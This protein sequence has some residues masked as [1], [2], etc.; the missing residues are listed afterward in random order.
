MTGCSKSNVTKAPGH[1]REVAFNT[2]FGKAPITRAESATLEYMQT[3]FAETSPAFH[4]NGFLH[5]ELTSDAE[6]N[7]D[8]SKV[9]TVAA[10]MSKDVWWVPAAEQAGIPEET[11]TLKVIFSSTATELEGA[12]DGET[13]PQGWS[14]MYTQDAISYATST[15]A[16]TDQVGAWGPW[17]VVSLTDENRT[18][19][20]GVWDYEGVTYW[21]DATSGRKLAFSAYSLNA[22]VVTEEGKAGIRFTK[23]AQGEESLT[24]FI[25]T[26]PEKVADQQDL[27]V[28]PLLPNQC[29]SASGSQTTVGLVFNHLLTRIGFS[30][31]AN[32]IDTDINIDIKSVT[33]NGVFPKSGVVELKD[34]APKIVAIEG[35]NQASYALFDNEG[36][37]CRYTSNTAAQPIFANVKSAD[38]SV[39]A[40]S[41][42]EDNRYMMIMPSTQGTDAYIEVVYQLTDAEEQTAKISLENWVFR[43]ST[44]YDFVLKVSTSAIGFYV[45]VSPWDHYFA[46][47]GT[48]GNGDGIFTLTPEIPVE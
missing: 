22:P 1:G 46:S 2:Y 39:V 27:L 8:L 26:V 6:G 13:I 31:M 47:T 20:G 15:Y 11:E 10:Y 18:N 37:F 25:Y 5:K 48:N 24:N 17:Q 33:L 44:S 12:Y 23:N 34:L 30:L 4:V 45:E 19:A 42:S 40:T 7:Y 28:T 36:E 38:N 29:V 21:P 35:N 9:S 16:V 3:K 14:D 43:P 41:N 32:R